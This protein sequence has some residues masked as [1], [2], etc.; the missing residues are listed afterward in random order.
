MEVL[1]SFI[2]GMSKYADIYDNISK[3]S[4]PKKGLS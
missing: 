2:D 1:Y 4:R 3:Y